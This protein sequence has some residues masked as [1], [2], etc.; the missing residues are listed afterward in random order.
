M[1]L[2]IVPIFAGI[3]AVASSCGGTSTPT[4]QADSTSVSKTEET[5]HALNEFDMKDTTTV[6]G[7]LYQY[8]FS[9][10]NDKSLPV[11]QNSFGYKYYDNVV[12][13]ALYEDKT[14]IYTH[15]FTKESF[16]SMIPA[17]DYEKSA[18]LGFNFNYLK[19]EEHSK[20]H[21]IASVGDCDESG[22]VTYS[23][24]VDISVSGEISLSI[25]NDIET[26]PQF[27]NMDVNPS[28]EDEV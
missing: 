23:I 26:G 14:K 12:L 20:F 19:A 5:I 3:V 9:F 21:F 17:A 16:R 11:I 15:R 4:N 24:A 10:K 25:V 6:N 22:K 28:E 2:S 8:D 27:D 1:K 18:L 7:K 13:L